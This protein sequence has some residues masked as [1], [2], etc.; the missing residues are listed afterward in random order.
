[1]CRRIR[2]IWNRF[3]IWIK[4]RLLYEPHSISKL[5]V[6]TELD[7][8]PIEDLYD[9]KKADSK[10]KATI[11]SK[12]G[13][14]VDP[15]HLQGTLKL[16]TKEWENKPLFVIFTKCCWVAKK[17]I[18]HSNVPPVSVVLRSTLKNFV[19][20]LLTLETWAWALRISWDF[21][22][23]RGYSFLIGLGRSWTYLSPAES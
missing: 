2:N 22:D 6:F 23:S 21:M 14:E 1:M 11:A 4:G 17:E 15:G 9:R 13:H 18:Q 16:C 8:E 12:L 19:L 5:K 20:N 3:W 7:R 10:T